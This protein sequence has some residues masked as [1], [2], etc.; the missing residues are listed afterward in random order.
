M[1]MTDEEVIERSMS[2]P[3]V[4]GLLFDRH[5]D[6]IT[7]FCVRRLG[8]V[9]GENLAGDVFRWAFENRRRFDQEHGAV[10]SWLFRIANNRVRNAR[11]SVNRQDLA[12]GRW[13]T[14]EH[15]EESDLAAQA[16][17]A[18]DAE[19]DL[20]AVAAA[21]ELQSGEDVETL[22]LFAWD[23]LSYREVAE[24]LSVPIGTV[25]SRISRVRDRLHDVLDSEVVASDFPRSSQGGSA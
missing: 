2:E 23:E 16:A 15:R 25:R 20:C 19:H 6:A 11:R 17:G 13:W 9:E 21:L 12:Y 18:V 10:R 7:R 4:F 8:T 14:Q 22:L 3:E 24:V 1:T 5:F